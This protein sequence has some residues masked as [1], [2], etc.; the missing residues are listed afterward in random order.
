M[1]W[2]PISTWK[3]E[4]TWDARAIIAGKYPSGMPWV[5]EGAWNSRGHW[6]GRKMEP[7]THW[8]PLPEPP[9]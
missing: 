6:R 7:P 3:P 2:Q 5:E 4:D 9:K 8:M 1:D